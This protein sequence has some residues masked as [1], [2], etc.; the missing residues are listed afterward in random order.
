MIM[1]DFGS[2]GTSHTYLIYG[3]AVE[4][5]FALSSV[6]P[7]NGAESVDIRIR[8]GTPAYF[9]QNAAGLRQEGEDAICYTILGDGSLYIRVSQVLEAV[10]DA[11]GRCVTAAPLNEADDR[12]FEANLT[13]FALSASLTMQGQECLH[14]TVVEID[15]RAI[16]LLGESGAGK[17]TLAAFL[18][19]GG[20]TL[21]T[22]DM[23]RVTFAEDSAMAHSGPHR[24]KLFEE[25]AHQLLPKEARDGRFNRLSRKIMVEPSARPK[26]GKATPL[27][28]LFWLG[29]EPAED[30]KDVSLR[31]LSGI[32]KIKVLTQ[33]TMARRYE[34]PARLKRQLRFAE[35]LA[36]IMPIHAVSYRRDYA[37]LESVAHKLR[38]TTF[39]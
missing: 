16:G 37:L 9:Q 33:S 2:T 26:V 24:L 3:V 22:D 31:R 1:P 39:G 17:S 20:A 27:S 18:L 8:V 21:I 12:T 6:E 25:T 7:W 30:A 14:A 32:E 13:N 28:A 36:R 29:E 10:V 5:E 38:Q 19:N 15:G 23:L 34:T 11:D 4:S 35:R